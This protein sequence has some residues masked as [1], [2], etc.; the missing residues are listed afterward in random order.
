[1]S[2]YTFYEDPGH[3]WLA[4]P[5]EQLVKLGIADKISSCSYQ[6]GVSAYLEEDCDLATFLRAKCGTI[7]A[8]GNSCLDSRDWR[9][10]W[11]AAVHSRDAAPHPSQSSPSAN[12]A[13]CAT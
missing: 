6:G 4:V 5:M 7:D 9:A 13:H 8:D 10:W 11:E 12:A 3:G 1:M 2:K